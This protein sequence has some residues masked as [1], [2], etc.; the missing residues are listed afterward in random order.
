MRRLLIR[1]A[2]VITMDPSL[3]D[4]RPGSILVE[5]ERVVTVAEQIHIVDAE[6]VDGR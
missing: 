6:V 4:L 3:G 2:T 5:D 1:D